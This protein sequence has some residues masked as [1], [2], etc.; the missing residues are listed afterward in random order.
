MIES[1]KRNQPNYISIQQNVWPDRELQ[2]KSTEKADKKS[3]AVKADKSVN[4]L[5]S[6][7]EEK[8]Y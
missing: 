4:V 6:K 8:E 2:L 1:E 5:K 7:E 3:K